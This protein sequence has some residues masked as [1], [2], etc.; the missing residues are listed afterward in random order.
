[1]SRLTRSR[2]DRPRS[3]W[4]GPLLLILLGG[5]FMLSNAGLFDVTAQLG[6]WLVLI[7]AVAL[8][9]TAIPA[10]RAGRW[11][12]AVLRG[13]AGLLLAGVSAMLLLGFDLGAWFPVLLVAAGVLLLIPALLGQEKA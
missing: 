1:M 12:G 10:A 6:G 8:L 7:P 4:I 3:G 5:A 2:A 13:L 9:V 11:R